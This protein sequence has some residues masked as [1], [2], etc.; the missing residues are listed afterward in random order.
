M[1]EFQSTAFSQKHIC[2]R[3]V[4]G[5]GMIE[6]RKTRAITADTNDE[7]KTELGKEESR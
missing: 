7:M 4:R 5:D 2:Y 1:G 6:G 3:I